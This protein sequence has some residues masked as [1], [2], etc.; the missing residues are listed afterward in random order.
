MHG[1]FS[2]KPNNH[3]MRKGC[4][5]CAG[6]GKSTEEFI[7]EAKKIHGNKYDYSL[8]D[9]KAAK[10]KIKIICKVHGAF[11]QSP[12]NHLTKKRGCYKCLGGVKLTTKEFIEKAK[13][14]HDNKYDYSLVEYKNAHTKV[15]I[16]CKVHGIFEQEAS[17]HLVGTGC[18]I[19]KLSKG[20]ERIY[21]YL[22]DKDISFEREKKF[23]QLGNKRFDFYLPKLNTII[24]FDGEQHF[25]EV[26][27]FGG[28]VG[29]RKRQ[30]SDLIKNQYCEDN[31]IKMLRIPYTELNNI[32]NILERG[33]IEK[34]N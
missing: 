2:Q 20:E 18:P 5:K 8:V 14:I 19:C 34:A 10:V 30:A 25:K 33:I 21:R 1:I 6:Y 22:V 16:I 13:L 24:E 28:E 3:L 17:S 29:F 4:P 27:F 11:E 7:Q 31:S 15:N 32:N 23:K 9:Y 26:D 12:N